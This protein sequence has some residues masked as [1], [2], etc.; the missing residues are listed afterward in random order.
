MSRRAR[1]IAAPA[2]DATD[3]TDGVGG[4]GADQLLRL[5]RETLDAGGEEAVAEFETQLRAVEDDRLGLA[6]QV[7]KLSQ[8]VTNGKDRFLRLNADF[9]NFRKRADREKTSLATSARG[10]VVEALLPVVD[11]FE[12]AKGSLKAE[13]EKEQKIENS[14]Q[15]IYK[16]LVDAL[17]GLGVV[18][19]ETMGKDFDPELH[20]AIMRG[21]SADVPEGV[22]MEEFRRGF[23][24][25]DRLLRPAMVKVSAGPGPDAAS[26]D[27]PS[28]PQ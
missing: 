7:S 15:N 25:H 1:S 6:S 17:R 10:D 8:E 21:E 2:E 26:S 22:V 28:E 11:N 9:D 5:F 14:Y 18:A 3:A 23:M 27:Q 24:I 16:Q 20:E 13:T 4:G 12:R 19:I